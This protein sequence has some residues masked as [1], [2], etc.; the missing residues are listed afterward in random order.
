MKKGGRE[1]RRLKKKSR[2]KHARKGTENA[3]ALQQV[4]MERDA[5][6]VEK[7]RAIS[8]RDE[9]IV[10]R[11]AAVCALNDALVTFNPEYFKDILP[12]YIKPLLAAL[13]QGKMIV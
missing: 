11:D 9:A 13:F 1:S 6:I 4:T 2:A 12:N 10:E 7:D 5:E 3:A 8:A